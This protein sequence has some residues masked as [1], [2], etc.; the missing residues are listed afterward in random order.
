MS[1]IYCVAS[2][3][4]SYVDRFNSLY[5]SMIKMEQ[6]QYHANIVFTVPPLNG[7]IFFILR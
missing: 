5:S 2:E 6:K 1:G 3:L 4:K 7:N